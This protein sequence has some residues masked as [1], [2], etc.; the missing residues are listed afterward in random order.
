M[1]T[2][3]L[4]D[5]VKIPAYPINISPDKRLYNTSPSLYGIFFEDIN[6]AGDGGIYAEMLINSAFD[7]EVIP[8]GCVYNSGSKT[9][10]LQRSLSL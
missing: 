3:T 4:N 10:I 9:K 1:D 2:I 6:R 8:Q 5:S 7:D